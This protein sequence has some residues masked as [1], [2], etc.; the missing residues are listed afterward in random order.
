[1]L[2]GEQIREIREAKGLSQGELESR[3]GLARVYISRIEN[4]HTM[5]SF[6]T[7]EKLAHA[8]EISVYQF[9]YEGKQGPA[10]DQPEREAVSESAWGTTRKEIR[11][12]NMFREHLSRLRESDRPLL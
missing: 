6:Q 7:L 2:I 12:W 3:T 8:L 9:F 11:F 1:M 10:S 5:P 4:G